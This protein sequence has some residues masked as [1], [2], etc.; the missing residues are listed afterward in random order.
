MPWIPRRAPG[1]SS[2]QRPS[3]E[4]RSV[5]PQQGYSQSAVH[6]PG[7]SPGR[8][9]ITGFYISHTHLATSER[10]SLQLYYSWG[11][12]REDEGEDRARRIPVSPVTILTGP[13]SC[14]ISSIAR[15]CHAIRAGKR[16]INYFVL[17]VLSVM[18]IKYTSRPCFYVGKRDDLF[19]DYLL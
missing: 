19:L 14:R 10:G 4:A 1:I 12:V 8:H 9:R 11:R 17:A 13:F 5:R 6:Q 2:R 18:P 7:E 16:K 3:A 15:H